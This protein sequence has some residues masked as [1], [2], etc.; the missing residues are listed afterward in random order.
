MKRLV[1]AL[2]LAVAAIPAARADGEMDKRLTASDK[3]RLARF[4]TVMAEALGEAKAGGSPEDVKRLEEAL[5]GSPLPLA[6]GFDPTG[7]WKCRTIKAGG[8]PPLVVYG[9]FKCRI[10]D[11][12][13]G[14]ML[15]K[16]TGSQR[17]KG[18]FYTLSASRLA[19]LGAGHYAD[20][21][22]RNYGDDPKRNQVAVVERRAD[23]RIV[24]MFP[25]PQYESK[26]DVLLL[27]R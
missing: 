24:L 6:E 18:R 22:P 20:E 3:D 8:D 19:Y 5:Q 2:L 23:N 26:L 15:E 1:F 17:T 11:D 25:A 12:G 27:E 4:D 14:W 7:D 16:L 10:S 13:A 21:A 9:W